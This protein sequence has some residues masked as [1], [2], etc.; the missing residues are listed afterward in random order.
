MRRRSTA[1]VAAALLALT[2]PLLA[3]CSTNAAEDA[4]EVET[5]ETGTE[6]TGTGVALADGWAKSVEA[7]GM[8]GIFGTLTNHGS[9]EL[10]I[11]RVESGVAETVELHEVTAEG[12]MREIAGDVVIPAGGSFEMAPGANHIMLM[13]LTQDLLAGD[14]VEFEV[15]FSDGSSQSYS[16]LVKD[17]AG[18]EEEYAGHD[19]GDHDHGAHEHDHDAHE[20]DDGHEH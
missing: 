20:H 10:V 12:I 15:H 17:Y 11:D 7:G 3:A 1:F 19:H 4:E 6:Q 13:G 16:V 18:A 14:D 9:D 8:T 5:A 2:A